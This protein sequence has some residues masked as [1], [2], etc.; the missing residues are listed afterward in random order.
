[1]WYWNADMTGEFMIDEDLQL[2]NCK[3]VSFGKHHESMC[4][5]DGSACPDRKQD[6]DQAGTRLM[7][8]LIAQDVIKPANSMNRLF[9]DGE[10][11]HSLAESVF[12]RIAYR[13]SKLET[14]GSLTHKERPAMHI[15][16]ALLDRLGTGRKPDALASLFSTPED[17]EMAIR[18]RVAKAFDIPL[19]NVPSSADE[20]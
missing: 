9:L 10:R 15:A 11:F 8:R 3:R 17:L 6:W 4:R 12:S 13:F 1:M 5:K 7:S 19:E 20:C 2:S 16:T 14:T 18:K